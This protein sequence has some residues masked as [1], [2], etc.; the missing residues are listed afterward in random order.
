[1]WCTAVQYTYH[2]HA[3]LLTWLNLVQSAIH[4]YS[5]LA[6]G[7]IQPTMYWLPYAGTNIRISQFLI[8]NWWDWVSHPTVLMLSVYLFLTAVKSCIFP[9]VI[10]ECTKA[11][12][13]IC[14][15]LN[16]LSFFFLN[17]GTCQKH[18]QTNKVLCLKLKLSV[19]THYQTNQL[20]TLFLALYDKSALLV[21]TTGHYLSN[22]SLNSL[23]FG[24]IRFLAK[25]WKI[26][27]QISLRTT[28]TVSVYLNI[29]TTFIS[30]H[31]I[32]S[33]RQQPVILA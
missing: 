9:L 13:I 5:P 7:Y 22:H 25:L 3:I 14:S 4:N 18:S 23:K 8:W 24:E 2:W 30:V 11:L 10:G 6:V 17:H 29:D 31:L 12:N 33:Y 20:K 21:K 32:W 19:F 26:W 28:K 15:S 1:M 16:C 27:K